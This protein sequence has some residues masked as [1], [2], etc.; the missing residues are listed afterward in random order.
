MSLLLLWQILL[1]PITLLYAGVVKLRNWFYDIGLSRSTRFDANVI[2]VGNL[3]IGGTG[4]SPMVDYLIHHFLG[5][6][7]EV[8]TLS[9]GFGRQTYGFRIATNHDTAD[10]IGDE[11]YMY[12]RKYGGI[13]KVGVAEDRELA[14]PQLLTGEGNEVVLMDDGFQHRRVIPTISMVLTTFSNPFYDDYILPSGRLRE[15]RAGVKR[16]DFVIVTKCPEWLSEAEQV[17]IKDRI[18]E[19]TDAAVYFT[20]I[21]Y[22]QPQPV[23]S[24]E[25]M[26]SN[27]LVAISGMSDSAPFERKL[28]QNYNVLLSHSYRDHHRYNAQDIR[29]IV[30]E[31]GDGIS[32]MVTEK[33][34]VKLKE[35]KTLE[36]FSCYYLPIKVKFLRDETLFLS[37]LDSMLKN[38]VQ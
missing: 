31:L 1:F 5:K 34:M 10:S 36:Q 6:Q 23:F 27:R 29:D 11:P 17:R 28:R 20:S 37:Q 24:N 13:V 26:L 38:Y 19:F 12:W 4:K 8:S 21:E 22:L 35:F 33:D 14:I 32:L 25:L 9:R 3:A 16:A 15:H 30:R 7:F 2:A 18:H